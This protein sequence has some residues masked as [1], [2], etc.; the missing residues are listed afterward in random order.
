MA[1]SPEW[2]KTT[3]LVWSAWFGMSL[4]EF[5]LHF[6]CRPQL[7][8]L[9]AAFT[10]FN[11]FLPKLLEYRSSQMANSKTLEDSLWDVVVFAI[12]GCPGALVRSSAYPGS[13]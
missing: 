11:V 4:G 7:I 8:L 3:L 5:R 12:G 10:M 1:L 2:L 9:V 6:R 13:S